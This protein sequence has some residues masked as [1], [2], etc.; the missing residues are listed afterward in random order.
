MSAVASEGS[1]TRAAE[2]INKAKSA[3][4]YS[5]KTL[6]EQ[7]EFDV[8]DRSKYVPK[9]TP[10]GEE[11]LKRSKKFLNEYTCFQDD[12]SQIASSVETRLRLSVSGIYGMNKVYDVIRKAMDKFP[13]TEIIIER[14]ILS[15]EKMLR[16]DIVDLAIFENLSVHNDFETR[17]IDE[18]EMKLVISMDHPFLKLPNEEQTMHSLK[19]YPQIIQRSTIPD[20]DIQIGISSDSLKWHVTDTASKKEVILNGLGWGRLP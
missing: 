19:Q 9:L 20:D 8:F 16:Q 4:I 3:I 6:E 1:F 17:H 12:I 18:V 10:K 14:E 15:G 13:S 2:K 5:I 7:L 11:F